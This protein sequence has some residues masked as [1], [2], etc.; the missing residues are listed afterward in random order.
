M[1]VGGMVVGG[2][3]GGGLGGFVVTVV[4]GVLVAGGE[5]LVG[6]VV[7]TTGL[8]VGGTSVIDATC[9]SSNESGNAVVRLGSVFSVFVV[10][11]SEV[12]VVLDGGAGT[13][14]VGAPAPITV[15]TG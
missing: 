1:I 8:G 9:G 3:V 10:F 4:A 11:C 2:M 12:T 13:G 6:P 7:A 15:V 14:D 5:A